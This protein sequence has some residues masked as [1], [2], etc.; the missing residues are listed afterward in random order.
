M[1]NKSS[2]GV[3][4]PAISLESI[5]PLI[6]KHGDTSNVIAALEFLADIFV[7]NNRDEQITLSS[8]S[9]FGL[10]ILLQTCAAA[11]NM[12]G[13]NNRDENE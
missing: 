4:A 10:I 12:M 5:N 13:N 2:P 1:T 6:L 7:R 9:C 3:K 11:L 8:D